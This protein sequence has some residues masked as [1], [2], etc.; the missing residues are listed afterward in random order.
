MASTRVVRAHSRSKQADC[1]SDQGT[2]AQVAE[3]SGGT[4]QPRARRRL[5]WGLQGTAAAGMLV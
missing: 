5:Q 4:G 3:A 2:G 1:C